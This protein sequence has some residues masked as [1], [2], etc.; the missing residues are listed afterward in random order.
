MQ[1]EMSARSGFSG[2]MEESGAMEAYGTFA[3]WGARSA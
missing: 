2:V 3:V 1:A